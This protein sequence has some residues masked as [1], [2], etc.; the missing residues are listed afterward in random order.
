MLASSVTNKPQVP[1]PPLPSNYP[2]TSPRAGG[3]RLATRTWAPSANS[4]PKAIAVIVHGGGWH[5]G[6]YGFLAEHLTKEQI[7]VAAY[8]QPG[9]GYSESDPNAPKGCIHVYSFDELV[10]EVYEAVDWAKKEAAVA[11][12]TTYKNDIPVFLIGESFGGV[13]VLSAAFEFNDRMRSTIGGV[14]VLGGSIRV[15]KKILPHWA[16][17]C[18]LTRI[19]PYYAKAKMPA[20]VLASTFDEAF[21]DEEWAKVAHSDSKVCVSPKYT[22]G[23]AASSLS[24]GE[25]VLERAADFPVPLLA[26]HGMRDCRTQCEAMIEFVDRVGRNA[27]IMLV[28]T[29]GHQLLQD[30]PQVTTMVV[31]KVASWLKDTIA[32]IELV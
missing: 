28:D 21:G 23:A 7:F 26:I 1:P 15:A 30:K 32:R 17:V 19:A 5:S 12:N 11:C 9:C 2:L 20:A 13:Q 22:L 25:T 14:V 6:Y 24:S 4:K 3:V 8:D 27:E 31:E 16:V 10:D 18:V 29:D